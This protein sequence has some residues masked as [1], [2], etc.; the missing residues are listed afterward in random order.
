MSLPRLFI[1][2]NSTIRKKKVYLG[3]LCESQKRY[4]KDWLTLCTYYMYFCSCGCA[5]KVRKGLVN[6]VH[7]L[8]VFLV[9][10]MCKARDMRMYKW[11]GL[12]AYVY[13]T[14]LVLRCLHLFQRLFVICF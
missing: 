3:N 7:I 5:K 1:G 2:V 6:F 8:Y 4:G 14:F 10:W 11:N 13:P 9:V 12:G